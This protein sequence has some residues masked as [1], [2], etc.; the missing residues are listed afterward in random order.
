MAVSH[1]GTGARNLVSKG[2]R[3]EERRKHWLSNLGG[4]YSLESS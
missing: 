3:R 2:E 4:R 1:V